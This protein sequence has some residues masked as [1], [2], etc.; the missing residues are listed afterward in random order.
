VICFGETPE[1]GAARLKVSDYDI[2]F[3]DPIVNRQ[4]FSDI[5]LARSN[6]Q[7]LAQRDCTALSCPAP[8]LAYGGMLIGK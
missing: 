1:L 6:K 5:F 3:D 8:R 2:W 7:A 4:F